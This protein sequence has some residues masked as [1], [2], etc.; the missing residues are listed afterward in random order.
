MSQEERFTSPRPSRPAPALRGYFT[1]RP[2]RPGELPLIMRKHI[3]TGSMGTAYAT[4]L[5]SLLFIFLGNAIGM[6]QFR[7]GVLGSI[8]AWVIVAQPLGAFLADRIAS[9]KKVWFWFILIERSLRIVAIAAGFLLW[10]TGRVAAYLALMVGTVVAVVLANLGSAP[11]WGWLAAIIPREVHGTFWGRRETWMA[12]AVV[13]V[14]IPSSL[15]VDRIPEAGKLES[16][17]IILGAVTALGLA[18][19]FIHGTI[20]EPA[21]SRSR[22]T[23]S[24][25][26]IVAPLRNRG[27]RPWLVF[28]ACW[29]F[30]LSLGGSLANLYF[31]ENLGIRNNLL[32]GTVAITVIGLGGTMLVA[33]RAGRLVDRLGVR[34]ILFVSHLCWSFLPLLWLLATP[35]TAV[36]WIG[37]ASFLGGVFPAFANNAGL[38]LVTRFPSPDESAMYTAISN[39]IASIAGGLGSFAAG[40]FLGAVGNWSFPLGSLVMSAFPLLFLMSTVLRLVPVF[41]LLPRIRET[42]EQA[43]PGPAA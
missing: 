6:T 11:W 29:T 14:A 15:I 9:R 41:A 24:P 16:V 38:K 37:L 17:V 42:G 22:E 34:R 30:G 43:A 35:G 10:T 7:W 18:D 20:P 8:S 12:L 33:R 2:V 25:S 39:T 40:A 31:M 3:Y 4:V 5:N 21:M 26:R 36:L 32:G 28:I 13:V 27:Y 19:V 1:Q 23:G